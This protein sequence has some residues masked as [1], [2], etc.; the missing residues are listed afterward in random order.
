M[1][2]ECLIFQRCGVNQDDMGEPYLVKLSLML[3]INNAVDKDRDDTIGHVSGTSK[4]EDILWIWYI[5]QE[6]YIPV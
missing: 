2:I 3:F 4:Y 6:T 5:N 1:I